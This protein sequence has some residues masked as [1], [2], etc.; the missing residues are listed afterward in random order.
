MSNSNTSSTD[1]IPLGSSTEGHL[2]VCRTVINNLDAQIQALLLMRK[3]VSRDAQETKQL[4]GRPRVD[5]F[6][7]KQIISS[8]KAVLDSHEGA[9]IAHHI[10]DYSKE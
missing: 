10:L 4:L 1:T 9:V 2:D 7:E 3:R 6:R 5:L 8:Y